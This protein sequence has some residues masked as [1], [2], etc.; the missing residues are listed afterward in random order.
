MKVG[1]IEKYSVYGFNNGKNKIIYSF[2]KL[3]VVA[4]NNVYY[5]VKKFGKGQKYEYLINK[6]DFIE[7]ER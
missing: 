2:E 4:E 6:K 1:Y 5:I 7:S 3:K